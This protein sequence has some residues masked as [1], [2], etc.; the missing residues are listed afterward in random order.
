MADL[1]FYLNCKRVVVEEGSRQLGFTLLQY[2][3]QSGWAGTK[4]VCSEGG[5]GA[6]TVILS[7]WDE[8]KKSPIH[9]STASCLVPL[10]S[11]HRKNIITVEGL[12]KL[13][14][15]ETHPICEAFTELGA[16]QCGFCTPGFIMTLE[17]RLNAKECLTKRDLERLFDGNLCRCTGYRPILDAASV[18]CEDPLDDEPRVTQWR[19]DYQRTKKLDEIFPDEYKQPSSSFEI[20]GRRTNWHLPTETEEALRPGT[21]YISGNTDVGYLEKY[22]FQHPT[23]KTLLDGVSE[24]K[25]ISD[26]SDA[27]VLGAGVTIEELHTAFKESPNS[28]L[29]ALSNQCRYFANTQ[30]RNHATL[31]GG[32]ISFNPYGDLVPVWIATRA[33]LSFSTPNGEEQVKITGTGFSLPENALLVSVT[34]PKASEDTHIESYKYARHRT[35]SITYVSGALSARFDQATNSFHAFIIS[36][37]GIGPSGF[38]ASETERFLEGSSL[39]RDVL[40]EAITHLKSEVRAAINNPL[41]ERVHAYQVRL[42]A[43]ILRRFQY[44]LRSRFLGENNPH[45]EDLVTRYPVVAHRAQESFEEKTDGILGRAIPHQNSKLQTTGAARYSVDYEVPHCLYGAI[46]PAP[47]ARGRILS[48]HASEALKHPDVVAVYTAE[49]IPGTNL[50][51][52]RVKDEEVLASS[53]VHYVGQPVGILLAKSLAAAKEAK[54]LVRIEVEEE[55]PI[56]TIQDALQAKSFHGNPEGYLVKQGD[57]EKGFEESVEIVE[58]EVNLCGQ[59]HFY[60]EPQSA[61][62]I[63]KDEGL[64]I[65][66]STQSPSNVVDHVSALL[67][68]KQNHVDVRVGRLGGGFGGKQLRAG[69]IAA[70]AALGARL[71]GSPVKL[72]LERK[73]DMAFCPGRG[74]SHAT[75]KAGFLSDGMINALDVNFHLSG[76]FSSDYSADIAETATLLMDSCYHIENVRVHGLCLKTNLGSNTSTRGFG[77]PQASAVVESVMDHGASVLGLDT[78]LLRRRNLY[79]KGHRTIT[80]TEIKDDVMANCWD[81]V[82]EKSNYEKLKE[83]VKTYNRSHTYTK[84]GIAVVGS[85]GNMGFIQTDDVN[86]G[87]ALIHIQ[88]D[89]TVSVTHSGTEMG[90][91]INTRM[92]QVA[93]DN[94]GIPLEHVEITDTQSSFIPNTPP[95]SMVSTDLCGEAILKAC[96]KLKGTLSHYKGSFEEKV[97]AAYLEGRSLTET[98]VHNAPRLVYD[99]E[100][101]QGD[102]SYFFVWGAAMSLVEIDVLSGHY[103]I[104][105]SHIVQDCGKSLNPLLD[106][107]QAEGGFLFGVGYYMTEEMIYTEKGRLISN[108]VSSYK[109]PGPGDI[110]LEWDIE[111]LNHDPNHSGLHNSKGI[112][113]SNVQLG[114]SVYFAAKEAVRAARREHALSVEFPMDF[115]ASVDRITAA[116]PDIESMI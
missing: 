52:F 107:G 67:K 71:S 86:R 64:L 87:L 32:V 58:G 114:L 62:A 108:N 53:R 72:T 79:E 77:K 8:I 37:S 6:C 106:V 109:I 36:F 100:K 70:I 111:L 49:D 14:E 69:P 7:H 50:F 102:I 31:G 84:R 60:L 45:E 83:E 78:N 1:E 105:K 5:C 25:G 29:K 115:P 110:P 55:V 104:I 33:T 16:T 4:E 43:A 97:Q 90:Q 113:E 17:A 22:A 94:L 98:G 73:E 26:G 41:P 57:L 112:G 19:E 27:V 28:A 82:M 96:A 48:I 103:R 85:K 34:V 9:R 12:S 2:L 20:Q 95:T 39:D 47:F 61:L 56:V 15:H 91:G 23:R 40:K 63:P 66:S 10:V 74:F 18:F 51:G 35:D 101:Q 24:L 30:I 65:Y 99:Y 59:Y 11:V 89:C 3:R 93:A 80:R 21:Q 75:Y 88:R 46:I 44:A 76:G 116:L 81:R 68:M 38:R 92:A 13:T 42:S 54:H